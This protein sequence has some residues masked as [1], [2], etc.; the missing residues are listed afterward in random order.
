MMGRGRGNRKGWGG[1]GGGL[2]NKCYMNMFS[3]EGE[4]CVYKVKGGG[5][6]TY[7]M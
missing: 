3:E 5:I 7:T 1:V 6:A 2:G 4:R